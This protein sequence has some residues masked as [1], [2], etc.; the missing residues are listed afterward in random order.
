[1]KEVFALDIG[2]RAVIGLIM[3]KTEQ[4]FNIIASSRTEH[5]QRAM[6]DG[7]VHDVDEVARAVLK[8]KQELEAKTGIKLKKV[9]VAAAGRAICTQT[10]SAR[11]EEVFPIIW[12]KADVVSLE[13]EAVQNALRKIGGEVDKGLLHCVGY[14]T[15][16][17]QLED[18]AITSLIGQ[19]GKKAEITVI[20]TF[21]PRSVVNGLIAV[22][23][24]I[25][26]EMETLTLEPIA[27][28]QAA[29]PSDMRRL[30]LALVDIGAG[31]ADIALTKEGSFF[32]YGMVPM[33]GDEVT[34]TL[35]S[36]YL[37]EFREAE[38]IKKSLAIENKIE[39]SN[40]FGEKLLL[41]TDEIL[42]V[43]KPTVNTIAERLSQE[44]LLL[45]GG[46]KPQAVILVG[47]GSLTP[48]LRETVAEK[49]EIPPS[50]VGIQVRERLASMLGEEE[51]LSG[52]DVITP[53][54][55]GMTALNNQGLHYYA[56]SVN[57]LNIP[58]FDLQPATVADTLL[59]AGIQPRSIVA[60][61]G[62]ALVYELNGEMK[63]LK[64]ELGKPAEISVNGLPTDLDIIT[65][66]G[67]NINFV[68][69]QAG[70]DAQARIKDVYTVSC[71]QIIF[72]G[73]EE[74]IRPLIL[75]DGQEVD[76]DEWLR[77]G[78]KL[79]I[80]E[81]N[82]LFAL[83]RAKGYSLAELNKRVISING[84]SQEIP[85]GLE[86]EIN[87]Q[88]INQDYIFKNN[89]RINLKERKIRLKDL[90]IAAEPMRFLVNGREFY[91]PPY[92]KKIFAQGKELSPD[93]LV[94]DNMDLRVEGFTRKP[95]LS[96]LFPYLNLEAK[97]IPGGRLQMSVN[98]KSA[99]FT[100]ELNPGDRIFVS[101]VKNAIS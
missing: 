72:N 34:E 43:I 77:D 84:R 96:E 39:I 33:A 3:Q 11:R 99:D 40:F 16:K 22:L 20:A 87:N 26:L 73:K 100:T 13:M 6:Y 36:H 90:D 24:R 44:I 65:K 56:V 38:K 48:L 68:P 62:A 61:P 78:C 92:E 93:D 23:R 4:G 89:D 10:A 2:T 97:T 83:L 50:R 98:G 67:D 32:A 14:S 29:I 79:I 55:I 9:A 70:A 86:V 1:M 85:P 5:N 45:N 53:I 74:Q 81:K 52:S 64:G 59:A 47:G 21:L 94:V 30:N 60:R 31:T 69:G 88:I 71:Q 8:V 42:E 63:I 91:L 37:L 49:M 15:T 7:Q 41:S 80:K 66:A 54:G 82:S 57:G 19:T 76:E 12:E 51:V 58:L 95:I 101:W 25:D 28:G 75:L 46:T 35:C 17:Q 27:A 18:L